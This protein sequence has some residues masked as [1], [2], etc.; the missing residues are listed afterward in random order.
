MVRGGIEEQQLSDLSLLMESVCLSSS[1]DRWV[2]KLSGDGMFSVKIIRNNL[3][4]LFLPSWTEP[5]RWVKYIPIKINVFAWRA[6]RDCLLTKVNLVRRGISLESVT[7][8]MCSL[9]EED[10]H[11]VFFRCE[12]AH[13]VLSF[14]NKLVDGK[15]MSD[16]DVETNLDTNSS[17][18]RDAEVENNSIDNRFKDYKDQ[19]LA[20]NSGSSVQLDVDTM[21]DEKTQYKRMYI[22]YKDV[23]DRWRGS[24]RRVIRLD[25]YFLNAT[26]KVFLTTSTQ[27]GLIMAVIELLPHAEHRLCTRHIYAN[28]KKKRNELHYKTLFLGAASSTLKVR[29][30][31]EGFG[32]N[33]TTKT[34]T[35]KWWDLSSTPC[36]HA[37]VAYSFL[38]QDA[39]CQTTTTTSQEEDYASSNFYSIWQSMDGEIINAKIAALAEMNEAEERKARRKDAKRVL[40]EAKRMGVL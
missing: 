10:V 8:S 15:Y 11:H 19:I 9:F 27:Q 18:S 5:T 34:C 32:V 25:S 28:F 29:K 21:D 33:L 1:K 23:K 40:E 4:D 6:M 37:V 2:C 20:T 7:C 35:C 17:S 14:L 36:V 26:C 30:A 16:K 38:N 3:D 39:V 13:D 12:M 31:D 24:C 22:C